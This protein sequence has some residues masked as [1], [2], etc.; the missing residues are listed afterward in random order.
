MKKTWE[1]TLME[2]LLCTREDVWL[3]ARM[4]PLTS[5]HNPDYYHP[6]SQRM[7]SEVQK[8]Q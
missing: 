7:Q 3:Y 1:L 5:Q 2:G 6:I 8:T 4:D